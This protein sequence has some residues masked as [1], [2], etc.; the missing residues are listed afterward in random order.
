MPPEDKIITWSY[1]FSVALLL[2][3]LP[4]SKYL[5]SISEFLLTAVFIT[6]G[7]RKKDVLDF[8]GKKG[9]FRVFVLLLPYGLYWI[10]TAILR[11]FKAF[12]HRENAPAWVFSSLLLLHVIGL[13]FTTDMD[14]ALKDLR[15]KLPILLLPLYLSTTGKVDRKVFPVLMYLFFASLFL[16]T[17]ISTYLFETKGATDI[18]DVSP[19]ISHIRFG[20]LID[21][22]I[23]AILFMIL[24]KNDIPLYGKALL[25]LLLGWLITFLFI[26]TSMTGLVILFLTAGIIILYVS[27]HKRKIWVRV[28]ITIGIIG[29]AILIFSYFLEIWKDVYREDPSELH[30]LQKV[31][32]LGNP[33]MNDTTNL[34][35]ENGHYV[36]IYVATDELRK[37]WNKRSKFDFDGKDLAG[38]DIKYTIIRFMTSRG[39]KKDADGVA[40]L[41][42]REVKLIEHGVAS[43]VYVN[44]PGLYVRIYKIIWEYKRY[45]ET[46][47]PTGH[48]VMQRFEF[49]RAASKIIGNN[50]LTGVGTGDMD[51]EFQKEYN[52]MNSLLEPGFRWRSHNQFLAI[53]VAFGVFGLTWFLVTL[54]FPPI[55]M[56]KFHDFYYLS[57]FIIIILSMLA[58]D[59]IETQA[60]ATTYAFFTSFYL[61]AKKFIDVV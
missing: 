7:I 10:F 1:Y 34:Q 41:T 29:A 12:F 30:H 16:G 44:N 35:V 45:R 57:F 36:W 38:Q 13:L 59:T 52:K 17:M 2:V 26:T 23:F 6:D 21:I 54:F 42:D 51:M 3:A 39:L 18:R 20:L 31:T 14:Y 48:S 58:E 50:W 27:Y 32:A 61:F 53:L 37:A 56:H 11:K 22:G 60:G 28:F 25:T 49:W 55:R 40:K 47:N 43:K 24:K 5:M 9:F 19:F 33:Y 46:H 8:F 15:V 4:L